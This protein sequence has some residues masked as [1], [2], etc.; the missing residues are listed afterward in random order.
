MDALD[1]T[2]VPPD[3]RALPS[4]DTLRRTWHRP[5]ARTPDAAAGDQEH[6]VSRV[7]FQP[8]RD[9]PP[10]AEGVES[11]YAPDARYRHKRDTQGTG[12]MV[13]VSEPCEPTAPHLLTHGHTTTAAV[14]EARCTAPIQQALVG[15]NLPPSE[16]VVDAADIDA[17]LLVSSQQDYGITLRG[18]ARPNP[19]WQAT[20]EGA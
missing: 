9:L 15:K 4:L 3:L 11:P 19:N 1:A 2:E 5:Y 13:H 12:S 7:R 8:N 14:H 16:H 10:A 20:V 17:E 18:P 6:P